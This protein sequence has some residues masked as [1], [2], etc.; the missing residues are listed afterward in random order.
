[1]PQTGRE[2]HPVLTTDNGGVTWAEPG[3]P[4]Y[5][6]PSGHL[7]HISTYVE[8]VSPAESPRWRTEKSLDCIP[9]SALFGDR[10]AQRLMTIS[11]A[12]GLCNLDGCATGSSSP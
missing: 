9:A 2:P 3:W 4:R 6:D 12:P 11:T 8:D 10:R 5:M 1:M 7:W